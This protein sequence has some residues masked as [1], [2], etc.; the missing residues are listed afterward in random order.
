MCCIV[1]NT[2]KFLPSAIACHSF[3][4]SS[5][6]QCYS[7]TEFPFSFKQHVL[8]YQGFQLRYDLNK[9]QKEKKREKKYPKHTPTPHPHIPPH[10][11]QKKPKP[12][13]NTKKLV[14][15]RKHRF[16]SYLSLVFKNARGVKFGLFSKLE[17]YKVEIATHMHVH[18]VEVESNFMTTFGF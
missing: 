14:L 11:P 12:T 16:F 8:S 18:E 13:P 10:P 7:S 1:S 4:S 3:H 15:V 6:F 9:L 5:Q 17:L 2:R